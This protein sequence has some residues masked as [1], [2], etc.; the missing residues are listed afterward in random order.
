MYRQIHKCLTGFI[1]HFVSSV[2]K[3][4]IC[5]DFTCGGENLDEIIFKYMHF[6]C[7]SFPGLLKQIIKRFMGMLESRNCYSPFS[8]L[9]D[10]IAKVNTRNTVSQK[11]RN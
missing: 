9:P 5:K 1:F 8:N 3:T 2:V 10:E 4:L 6:A 7:S 11:S